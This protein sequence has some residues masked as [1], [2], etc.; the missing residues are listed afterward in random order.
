MDRVLLGICFALMAA[1]SSQ[2]A[3]SLLGDGPVSQCARAAHDYA[4]KDEDLAACDQ[5]VVEAAPEDKAGTYINRGVLLL[6]RKQYDAARADFD[7]AERLNPALGEAVINRG[8]SY[9]AQRRY[10]EGLAE[11]DRG[12]AL[13]PEEPEKAYYNRAM[14]NEALDDKEAAYQDY[15]IAWELAPHWDAPREQMLR[16]RPKQ[17]VLLLIRRTP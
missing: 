6:R 12:L 2:A 8:A 14:A 10:L 7:A 11:I 3:I 13:N 16:L 15:T 1:G 17:R 5:A 9:V 4:N